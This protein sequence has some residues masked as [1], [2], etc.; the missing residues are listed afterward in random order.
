MLV[1][2]SVRGPYGNAVLCRS[3]GPAVGYAVDVSVY[4]QRGGS[5]RIDTS[6]GATWPLAYVLALVCA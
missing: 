1:A 2:R 6:R 4:V 3:D 5:G